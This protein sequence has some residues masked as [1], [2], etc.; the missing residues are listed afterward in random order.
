MF[1]SQTIKDKWLGVRQ[2]ING[3]DTSGVDCVCLI[4]GIY[5]DF[6]IN[7]TGR[8]IRKTGDGPW[9]SR[10]LKM[11]CPM[12]ETVKTPAMFDILLFRLHG[13]HD[14]LHCGISLGGEEFLHIL[15]SNGVRLGNLTNWR[16]QLVRIMRLR[17][18]PCQQQ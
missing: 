11:A 16:P 17:G 14:I 2:R 8:H 13:E 18:T 7:L 9:V 5:Y 10:M 1:D 15:G 6:G 12:L 4:Y 3:R